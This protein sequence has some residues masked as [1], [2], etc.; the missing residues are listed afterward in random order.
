[1][2]IG[3]REVVLLRR[4]RAGCPARQHGAALLVGDHLGSTAL[5]TNSSGARQA[6]LRYFAYGKTRYIYGTTPTTYRY[7]G[8]RQQGNAN[9][10]YYYNARWYDP[11][12]GRFLSADT[13]VPDP[14]NPQG[15]NRYSYGL[16]NPVKYIDPTGHWVETAWDVL[17]IGWDIYEVKHDPSLLNIGALV[18]D[19]GAA[20]LPFV[21][22]GV[23]LIARGGKAAKLGITAVSRADDVADVG[24]AGAKIIE[25][26]SQEIAERAGQAAAGQGLKSFTARNFRENLQ[27]LTGRSTDMIQGLEAHHALPQEFSDRFARSNIDINDP[28]FGSW[29][30]ATAH[31]GWSYGY[32][33]E[34][35]QFFSN[36]GERVPSQQ[37]CLDFARHLAEKYGFDLNF[38]TP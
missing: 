16:G 28:R 18:V 29:V 7:T 6:E 3:R 34:W 13:I 36:F 23:G 30:D 14:K 19:A 10:L 32:N 2:N 15:L 9:E 22:A 11:L 35:E 27:R 17:N 26:A 5:T 37:E 8:Q 38:T 33:R 24:K 25:E 12:V 4:Q 21:P 20:I 31:R 1:V